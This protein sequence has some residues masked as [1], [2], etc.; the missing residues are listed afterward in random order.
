MTIQKITQEEHPETP[1]QFSA[2]EA[3][4]KIEEILLA[5][6]RVSSSFL[7]RIAFKG[8]DLT[9]PITQD[10]IKVMLECAKLFDRKQ[11]DYGSRNI[12]GWPTKE[13]NI[14]GVAVRLNDKIQR[15][16]NLVLKQIKGAAGPRVDDES[17]EDTAR[18]ICNYGAIMELLITDRWK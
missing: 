6:P 12:A 11:S 16:G 9:E 18:D 17:L 5:T 4:A 8:L 13:L 10:T 1:E 2:Q 3:E 7:A 15:L 14:F